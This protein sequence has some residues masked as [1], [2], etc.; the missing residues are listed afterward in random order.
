MSEPRQFCTVESNRAP[1]RKISEAAALFILA[2]L[3][4]SASGSKQTLAD[5]MRA[6]W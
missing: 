2:T 1:L 6:I 4:T 5:S 3:A